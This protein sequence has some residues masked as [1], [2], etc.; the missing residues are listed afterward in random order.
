MCGEG[1]AQH[2]ASWASPPCVCCGEPG[3]ETTGWKL[4]EHVDA[5]CFVPYYVSRAQDGALTWQVL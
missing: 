1:L 3:R 2:P 5:I 4:H